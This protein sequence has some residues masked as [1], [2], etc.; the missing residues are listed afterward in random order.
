MSLGQIKQAIE[1][2]YTG[3]ATIYTAVHE[4]N[5]HGAQ[6]QSWDVLYEEIP[7]RL[8]YDRKAAN[9]QD[10]YGAVDQDVTLYCDP[11]YI[12]PAGAKVKVVQ[13]GAERTYE[14]GSDPA[15]YESHQEVELTA[16]RKRA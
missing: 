12:I 15:V 13:N 5:A 1:S 9:S 3:K 7:C 6:D 4:K 10:T 14:C 11:S 8:S 16:Y 2:L